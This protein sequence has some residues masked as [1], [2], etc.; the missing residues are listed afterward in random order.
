M[1]ARAGS[2]LVEMIGPR[3]RLVA[4]SSRNQHDQHD[5]AAG[6]SQVNSRPRPLAYAMSAHASLPRVR[7]PVAD[8][9]C[10]MSA[11]A[12]C[13]RLSLLWPPPPASFVVCGRPHRVRR[14]RAHR[15]RVRRGGRRPVLRRPVLCLGGPPPRACPV[16]PVLPWIDARRRSTPPAA[17]PAGR[18]PR[19]ESSRAAAGPATAD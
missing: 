14:R 6:G 15:R 10:E 12:S 13:R 3:A 17:R 4:S 2:R 5:R 19:R 11:R 7:T 9:S 1:L 18:E 8:S 16:R